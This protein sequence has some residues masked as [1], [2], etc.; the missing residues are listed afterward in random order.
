MGWN[1]YS[2]V[3]GISE[4]PITKEFYPALLVVKKPFYCTL[5]DYL[6]EWICVLLGHRFCNSWPIYNLL[7]YVSPREEAF[8]IIVP[9]E[10]LTRYAVWRGWEEWD[11]S[12]E[13]EIDE[14]LPE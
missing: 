8:H 14:F 11:F 3:V 13:E 7:T 6:V 9:D 10:T 5:L 12:D 4:D 2:T 1:I